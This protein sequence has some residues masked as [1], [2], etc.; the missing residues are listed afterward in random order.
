M[1]TLAI[2]RSSP[3]PALPAA[4]VPP[5]AG[6]SEAARSLRSKG[7]SLYELEEGLQCL[8]DSAE[9]VT[10]EQEEEFCRDLTIA[11]RTVAAKRDRYGQFLVH[12][13]GLVATSAAEVKRLQERKR[14]Y[15]AV[16][17]RC[18]SYVI[19]IIRD[20]G[21]DAKNR[22]PKLEGNTTSFGIARKPASVELLDEAAVPPEFK[23]LTLK[24]PATLWGRILDS[25]DLDLRGELLDVVKTAESAISRTAIKQALDAKQE[26]PGASMAAE[27]YRLVRK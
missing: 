2:V 19:R 12:V 1:S 17:E 20:M 23:T 9:T 7:P 16:L 6:P 8:L 5:E 4:S 13:E 25:L 26:V 22:F 3:E 27:S 15:E 11:M 14:F 18:E 10:P 24:M 21:A